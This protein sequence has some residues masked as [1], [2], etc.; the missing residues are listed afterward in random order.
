MNFHLSENTGFNP[1]LPETFVEVNQHADPSQKIAGTTSFGQSQDDTKL[2]NLCKMGS[3]AYLVDGIYRQAIDKYSELFRDIKLVGEEK[4]VAYLKYRLGLMTLQIGEDWRD[5][6]FRQITEYVKV[7][8]GISLKLRGG[9]TPN[10]DPKIKRI[11]YEAKPYP[12]TG[13]FLFPA[14]KLQPFVEKETGA[15]HGWELAERGRKDKIP[16]LKI[17]GSIP[18]NGAKINKLAYKA[19]LIPGVDLIHLAYK[20]PAGLHFGA[21][22]AVSTIEDVSLLRVLE[23]AIAVMIKKNASPIIHHRITRAASPLAGVQKEIIQAEYLHRRAAPDGVIITGPNHE[24]K[25]IGS[26]SQ[27]IRAEGYLKYFANRVFAGLGITPFLMGFETG[28]LGAAEAALKL[29]FLRTEYCKKEIARCFEAFFFNELL[30]EG[31]FDPFTREADQVHLEFEEVDLDKIVKQET[32]ATDLYTKNGITFGELRDI[33]QRPRTINK[34]D[35]Y[36]NQIQRPLALYQ[37][38]A[39]VGRFA[40][41][42]NPKLK[43]TDVIAPKSPSKKEEV[44]N[45]LYEINEIRPLDYDALLLLKEQVLNLIDDPEAIQF[46]VKKL[47]N[48]EDEE[49]STS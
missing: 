35:L 44:D 12:I 4:P 24:I 18:F 5:T 23:Q 16:D 9:F 31:G 21:G 19:P 10:K 3:N 17:P 41:L 13:L 1:L 46:L 47:L 38:E 26:E 37:G 8:N 33:L 11:M 6:L 42:A 2:A 30:W 34:E 43:V 29:L 20:K 15:V 28:T 32:H 22:M 40:P 45:F 14:H 49:S 39:K 48:G 27:A 25:A 7:G 36:L